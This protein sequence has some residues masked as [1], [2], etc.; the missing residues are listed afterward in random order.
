[1]DDYYT[2]APMAGYKG[3]GMAVMVDIIAG[4]LFGGGTGDR[5]KD[6]AEGPSLM[7]MAL[8]IKAFN[9]EEKYYSDVDARIS[10]LKASK[11]AKNSK[12]I[13]M[14]GEIESEKFEVSEKT[15]LVEVL[16]ENLK[17]VNDLADEMNMERIAVVE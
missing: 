2:I 5:A 4:T 13:L 6:F 15:G 3:W 1:M 11:L 7:M 17:M 16:P 10:E 14:P 8:D 12:G 9:D